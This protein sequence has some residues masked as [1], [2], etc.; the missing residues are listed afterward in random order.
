MS[1]KKKAIPAGVT[2]AVIEAAG[3]LLKSKS[4]QKTILGTYSDGKT[5]SVADAIE[6]EFLSPKQKAKLLHV[7]EGKKNK[8]GKKKGKKK[9]KKRLEDRIDVT[10]F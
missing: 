8:K 3:V 1:K 7:N 10:V 2:T 9:S 6:G 5:R 4:V